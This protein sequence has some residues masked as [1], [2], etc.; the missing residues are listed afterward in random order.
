MEVKHNETNPITLTRFILQETKQ[1]KQSTG[2]F[3]LLLQS[4]QLA[5][6]VIASAANK[7]GIANLYGVAGGQENATGDVQK[8]L[9]V[10][11]ND[12]FVNCLTFSNQ[13]YVMGSEEVEEPIIVEKQSGGYAVV[14]DPL[15]GSSNIDANVSVGTIFGIYKKDAASTKPTTLQD[16]TRPGNEL[17][18]SGY[19]MYGA[20]TVLV[21]TTGLGVNGFLLDPTI[22]EFILTH[23]NIQIPKKA[24]IYSINEGN[25]NLWDAPTRE[26]VDYCKGL[27]PVKSDGKKPKAMKARYIGSMVADIH[28][29][30]LYGGVF[31]YPGDKKS[32]KGKLRLIYECNPIAYLIEQAGGRASNGTT[33]ILDLKPSKLH[34]RS[35]IFCGSADDMLELEALYRKHSAKGAPIKSSL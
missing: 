18:A 20:A 6:K 3:A 26:F 25:C 28:R 10:L 32:P 13:V 31:C 15:D 35:P 12:V 14:F 11:A 27:G 1:F 33:R 34:E 5:C 21:L 19:A 23:R 8:K 17:L 2:N 22:G 24:D 7:A 9:D 29:T 30:L 16:L 4:I